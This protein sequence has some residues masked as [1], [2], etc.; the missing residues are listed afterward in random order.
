M[1]R[2]FMILL[3]STVAT[4]GWAQQEDPGMDVRDFSGQEFKDARKQTWYWAGKNYI[5]EGDTIWTI[6][7]PEIPIYKPLKFRSN[8]EI[9]RYNRL[10]YNVKKVL[11]LAQQCNAMIQETYLVMEKL[12]DKKSKQEHIKMI[13]EYGGSMPDAIG[14]PEDML[15]QAA[16]MAVCKVNVDS[17]IRIAMTAALRKHLAENP[18]HFDPRQYLVPARNLIEEVVMHKIDKVFGS[19]GHA[20]D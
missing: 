10:V 4:M 9:R 16:S 1:K 8:K 13:N 14:I 3:A 6:L 15:R 19:T 17:D 2:W 20:F 7:M 5:Y 11:P 18:T 12:P